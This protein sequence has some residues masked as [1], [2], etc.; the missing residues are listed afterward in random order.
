MGRFHATHRAATGNARANFVRKW[1]R[2][3]R[4]PHLCAWTE[5]RILI[6]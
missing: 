5:C 1:D 3:M 4:R 6:G 2:A